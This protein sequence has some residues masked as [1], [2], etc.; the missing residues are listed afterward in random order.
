MNSRKRLAIAA[1]ATSALLLSTTPAFA[2]DVVLNG[3][4]ATFAAPLIDACRVDYQLETGNQINYS[5]GGS[6]KGRN[7]FKAGLVPFAGSDAAYSPKVLEPSNLIYAPIFAAPIAVM[8]NLPTVKESIY[9]SPATLAKI[10]SGVITNWN[11]PDIAKD[12]ERTVKSPVF[13][14]KQ[15]KVTT[16]N[17][18]TKKKTTS[19]KTVPALDSSGQAIID[20]YTSTPIN[21]DLPNQAITV[22]YRSESSGTSENFA[23]FLKEANAAA[24]PSLWPKNKNGTFANTTPKSLVNYFNFQ[25]ASGSAAVTAG[26]VKTVG[27]ISYSELSFANDAKL[28]IANILN[29][30]GEWVAPSSASTTLF[31]GGGTIAEDGVV[32]YDYNKKIPGAYPLGIVSYGLAGSSGSHPSIQTAVANWFTYV[33]DKCATKYPDKGFAQISGPLYDKAKERISKIK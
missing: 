5:G 22:W 16:I 24:N 9:L 4:G 3:S 21:I 25:G 14:T 19:T 15:V 6:G 26:V 13:K 29:A 7:D 28:G 11:H 30:A 31:I 33:L 18:K 27:G 8:Y 23:G 10:F 1:I 32:T 12:N 2:K 17:K 20:S